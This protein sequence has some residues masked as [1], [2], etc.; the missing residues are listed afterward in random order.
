MMDT[1]DYRQ[2][3]SDMSITSSKSFND[4]VYGWLVLHSEEEN[5]E[6]FLMKRSFVLSKMEE[7]FQMTRKTLAKYFD[8]LVKVGLVVDGKDRWILTDLGTEGFW[9]ETD[10]LARLVETR[11]KGLISAYV[12][13]KRGKWLLARKGKEKV[14]IILGPL[15]SYIGV[16]SN[17]KGN[18]K[19]VVDLLEELRVLGLLQYELVHGREGN[20]QFYVISG[21]GQDYYF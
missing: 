5:E 16:A 18:N 14:P 11:K 1:K 15:K 2:V 12:Y 6:R 7:E 13:L 3:V 10:I 9:L 20:R 8:F 21:V 4:F 19:S 17:T